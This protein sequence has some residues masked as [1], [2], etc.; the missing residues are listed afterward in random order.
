MT[1]W[2]LLGKTGEVLNKISCS[3]LLCVFS[4]KP[5]KLS[6]CIDDMYAY[7]NLTDY[8][9]YQILLSNDPNLKE[10]ANFLVIG[11]LPVKCIYVF[12]SS[13]RRY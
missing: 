2:N 12:S 4:S 10:V 3:Y 8:V 7:T 9:L 6:Q 13:L 5:V 1:I 11:S